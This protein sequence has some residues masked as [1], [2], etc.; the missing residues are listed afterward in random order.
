MATTWKEHIT[1]AMIII[2]GILG[3]AQGKKG[4]TEER[5]LFI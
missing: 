5:G 3:V 1:Q 2:H 4:K